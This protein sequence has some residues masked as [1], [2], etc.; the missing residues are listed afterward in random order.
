MLELE[1][2]SLATLCVVSLKTG[3]FASAA[4]CH[5]SFHRPLPTLSFSTETQACLNNIQGPLKSRMPSLML[6]LMPADP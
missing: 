1:V 6:C 3:G 5:L 4:S 2:K